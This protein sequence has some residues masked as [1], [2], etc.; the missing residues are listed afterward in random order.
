[1]LQLTSEKNNFYLL[2]VA[3]VC[4]EIKLIGLRNT[5]D[6]QWSS[7]KNFV[8]DWTGWPEQVFC[9]IFF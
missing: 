6:Y 9:E 8:W 2:I 1:M 3:W 4:Q 7:S 5:I